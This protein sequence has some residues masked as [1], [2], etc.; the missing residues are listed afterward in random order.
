MT[1]VLRDSQSSWEGVL[2][3]LF[4]PFFE[5]QQRGYHYKRGL[6]RHQGT[7][8]YLLYAFLDCELF[9]AVLRSRDEG[10]GT[11]SLS[12]THVVSQNATDWLI[13][14]ITALCGGH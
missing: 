2:L 13:G 6:C 9:G 5:D 4:L 1:M 8:A 10:N 12:K 14:A 7:V 11:Q 3:D